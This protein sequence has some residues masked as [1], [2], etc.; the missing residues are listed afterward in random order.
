MLLYYLA[1][2]IFKCV[3]AIV[4]AFIAF[5]MIFSHRTLEFRLA[6]CAGLAVVT[7]IILE[8]TRSDRELLP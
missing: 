4:I 3:P 5:G 6:C 1:R 2:A 7:W 8:C